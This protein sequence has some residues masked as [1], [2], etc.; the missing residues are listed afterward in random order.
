MFFPVANGL[1]KAVGGLCFTHDQ[2]D[3]QIFLIGAMSRDQ[4]TRQQAI[5]PKAPGCAMAVMAPKSI[6]FFP[7]G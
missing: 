4:A 5:L 3:P 7:I 6:V 1:T 2:R